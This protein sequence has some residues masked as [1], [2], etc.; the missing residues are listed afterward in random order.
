[1]SVMMSPAITAPTQAQVQTEGDYY[2]F[3]EEGGSPE[4]SNDSPFLNRMKNIANQG[5]YATDRENASAPRIVGLIINALLS[6]TGI[7]FIVLTV[8]AGFNW[9]TSQG[10]EEKIKKSKDTLKA[11]IIGLI[12]TLSAWTIWN[13]IFENLILGI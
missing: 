2:G 7:I 12:V 5:G 4:S 9:M 1:M 8:F 3:E 13:F 6:I 11:S 10:N